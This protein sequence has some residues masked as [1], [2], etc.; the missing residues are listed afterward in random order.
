MS[1]SFPY[2]SPARRVALDPDPSVCLS[3]CLSVCMYVCQVG[4]Y[5][6]TKLQN[7]WTE[8]NQT[9]YNES[10]YIDV[11]HLGIGFVVWPKLGSYESVKK[12]EFQHNSELT[13][14]QPYSTSTGQNWMNFFTMK[15]RILK[16][17]TQV[18]VLSCYHNWGRTN[19]SKMR[20]FNTIWSLLF[21]DRQVLN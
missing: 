6:A 9:F 7:Y 20:N 13:F 18:L 1:F 8:S 16:L 10:V 3:V 15:E 12:E 17:Y 11:V 14:P 19:R 4:F 2:K 5:S 21:R